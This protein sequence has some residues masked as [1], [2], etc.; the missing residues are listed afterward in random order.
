MSSDSEDDQGLSAIPESWMVEFDRYIKTVEAIS[1]D[2]DIVHWWGV[3]DHNFVIYIT[4]D[5][6]YSSMR[7]GIQPGHRSHAITSQLWHH[8]YL[9]NDL[10]LQLASLLASV[11][12][13]SRKILLRPYNV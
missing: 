3:G 10:F 12:T 7:V 8:W 6:M 2:M 9:V 13:G 4:I 11:A 5:F 1:K